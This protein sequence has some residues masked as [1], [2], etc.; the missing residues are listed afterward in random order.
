MQKVCNI[1]PFFLS[2]LSGIAPRREIR[3]WAYLSIEKTIGLN[4]S[5]TILKSN[6]I[7]SSQ[8]VLKLNDIVN[9][10]SNNQP[11]HQ[12]SDVPI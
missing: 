12:G 3:N 5:D 9:E 10:L 4:R 11:I 6:M 8:I 2:R 1:I 7:L